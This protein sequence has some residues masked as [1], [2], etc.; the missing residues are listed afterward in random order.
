[1]AKNGTIG[2]RGRGKIEV[3]ELTATC[4]NVALAPT[5]GWRATLAVNIQLVG[6]DGQRYRGAGSR[7][8]VRVYPI[9][10][11]AGEK[12]GPGGNGKAVRKRAKSAA[13]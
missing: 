7:L 4:S 3:A 8:H 12:A 5:G 9:R 6:P 10:Q 13:K 11:E 2:R 1:M